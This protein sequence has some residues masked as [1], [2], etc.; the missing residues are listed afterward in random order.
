MGN[1]SVEAAGG[2]FS[3]CLAPVVSSDWLCSGTGFQKVLSVACACLSSREVQTEPRCP[4]EHPT[5]RMLLP[6]ALSR[7]S[8]LCW[9]HPQLLGQPGTSGMQHSA[10]G[11]LYCCK[12]WGRRTALVFPDREQLFLAEAALGF[13]PAKSL[14]LLCPAPQQT[15]AHPAGTQQTAWNSRNEQILLPPPSFGLSRDLLWVSETSPGLAE[16]GWAF[17]T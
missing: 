9:I 12:T 6:R 1:G 10:L 2:D 17:G 8:W 11:G 4:C 15:P 13:V 7:C 3:P 16:L 5:R 14:L